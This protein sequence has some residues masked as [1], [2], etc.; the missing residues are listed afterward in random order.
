M[1]ALP[2]PFE[3]LWKSDRGMTFFLIVLAVQVFIVFPL[4]SL[5]PLARFGMDLFLSLMMISGA[6]TVGRNR[7]VTMIFVLATLV[8]LAVH[9]TT[10]YISSFHHPAVDAVFVMILFAGFTVVMM[11]QVF[12]PGPITLH[13]VLGAVA[14]YL[15]VGVTWGYAYY[16]AG[17]LEPGAL[18]FN[19]PTGRMEVDA[20][21]YIYFSM[22]TLTTIGFGDVLPIHPVARSLAMAEALIGQL[23]PAIFIAGLLGMALQG[24]P[25]RGEKEGG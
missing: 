18:Q 15:S 10:L 11:L 8:G 25:A 6:V 14:A 5:G 4:A 9:W 3:S 16:L 13:R 7:A 12:R 24:R 19:T 22:T 17:L 21:R 23:Y 2:M 20:S 1:K